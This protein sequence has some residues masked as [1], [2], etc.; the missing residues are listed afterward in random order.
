MLKLVLPLLLSLGT[1]DQGVL[2]DLGPKVH[3][4]APSW[5]VG[6]GDPWLRLDLTHRLVTLYQGEVALTAYRL[7]DDAK[8]APR[9]TPWP[10]AD[11]TALLDPE[12][13]ADL[14]GRLTPAAHVT[15]GTPAPFEDQDGDGIVNT[16][17][18]LVGAKKLCVNKAR[19]VGEYRP[20]KYPGGDVPRT[21]GVCTDTLIRALRNAGWD[22]Q[23]G[24]HE[25]T[26]RRPKAYPLGGKAPDAN[27][28]HRRIRMLLPWFQ[29]NFVAVPAGDP[30]LPGDIVLFDTFPNKPG[31]DHAGIVSDRLASSGL[32]LVIN[33]WDDG[34]TE[35]EMDLLPSVP[36]LH[37]F[38]V[39]MRPAKGAKEP[40]K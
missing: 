17:D 15:A 40:G 25:D 8:P 20:L 38:R 18:V 6:R 28:D 2:P 35:G 13:A 14:N 16:L 1:A 37:R 23:R 30:Y 27:I 22:L 21:E 9:A 3:I 34:Y 32:P 36:V 19:Y 39:P 7:R 33:N 4:T 29:Q 26:L 10:P 31:A 5:S 11:V 12:D 24:V